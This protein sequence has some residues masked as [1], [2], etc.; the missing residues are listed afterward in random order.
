MSF[1]YKAVQDLVDDLLEHVK[2]DLDGY[3]N[4][5]KQDFELFVDRSLRRVVKAMV[6]AVLGVVLVTAGVI[7]SLMGLV[8]Y[9]SQLVNPAL[10][11]A[12]V[13]LGMVGLG[14][15]LV[16]RLLRRHDSG[17][18]RATRTSAPP[19]PR[20]SRGT[21]YSPSVSKESAI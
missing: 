19:E 17:W 14:A 15:V 11:W 21:C 5:A 2:R 12:I 4:T 16:L 6:P 7:F 13:G 20:S 9:L 3:A 18:T 10:A 1:V 8:T